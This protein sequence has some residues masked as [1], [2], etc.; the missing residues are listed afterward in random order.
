MNELRLQIGTSKWRLLSK[1]IKSK[2]VIKLKDNLQMLIFLG[3]RVKNES[4]PHISNVQRISQ[5]PGKEH[6]REQLVQ[7]SQTIRLKLL[8]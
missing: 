4:P 3:Y 2:I 7:G 1:R 8:S 5:W 6:W